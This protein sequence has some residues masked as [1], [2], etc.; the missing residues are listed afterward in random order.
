MKRLL[1]I[2]LFILQYSGLFS[3]ISHLQQ[4]SIRGS[5][6][7]NI[8]D[9]KVIR[10]QY[11]PNYYYTSEWPP[12]IDT[13]AEILN[14]SFSL[15]ITP[16]E[17]VGYILITMPPGLDRIITGRQL[18]VE[19]GDNIMVKFLEEGVSFYGKDKTK[20]EL[21]NKLY[22]MIRIPITHFGAID[23]SYIS[24]SFSRFDSVTTN[25]V[26]LLDSYKSEINH[27]IYEILKLDIQTE[28]QAYRLQLLYNFCVFNDDSV[29][30]SNIKNYYNG[31]RLNFTSYNY[32][33]FIK[34]K[35]SQYI[36]YLLQSE[37]DKQYFSSNS[38]SPRVEIQF[39]NLFNS[40]VN[41]YTGPVRD[42]LLLTLVTCWISSRKNTDFYMDKAVR[43]V[44][45]N[46]SRKILNQN[47]KIYG[48]GA[49]AYNFNLQDTT[50]KMVSLSE[51][52]GRIV[53]LDFY[54]TGCTG[55]VSLAHGMEPVAKLYKNN[56]EVIFVSINVD[57]T[58]GM[59][60]KA[61]ISGKY[62]HDGYV[63]LWTNGQGVDHELIK[64]YKMTGFPV[65]M[66]IDRNGNVINGS[67]PFPSTK[68]PDQT[69][70]F[71]NIIDKELK[72]KDIPRK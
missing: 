41:N 27:D 36:H 65:L 9:G 57:Q 3:Q 54:F 34:M 42:R 52:R 59:F 16:D 50:G 48:R 15:K 64:Y 12:S 22:D 28:D 14:S 66:V 70:E 46:Y 18:L 7:K 55:C 26:E 2:T 47:G 20:F 5:I 58:L 29:S 40:V 39:D 6:E 24:Q 38:K 32:P 56:P 25:K 72:Q 44:R 45:E 43:M 67:P 10:I 31:H 51:L 61:V 30:Y 4:I 60:K 62:T 17:R 8:Y 1:L 13:T 19:G 53:I 37:I 23:S 21:Q 68:N 49:K 35:S 63:N 71:V 11:Y 69:K 33:L